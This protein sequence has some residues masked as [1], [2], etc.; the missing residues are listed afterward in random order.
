MKTIVISKDSSKLYDS[1]ELTYDDDILS[2]MNDLNVL[3]S[4]IVYFSA[5]NCKIKEV[6][7]KKE[8]SYSL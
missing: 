7:I 8:P 4:N 5:G 2:L 1:E 6:L 3:E